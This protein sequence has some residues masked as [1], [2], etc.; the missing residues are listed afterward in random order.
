MLDR[1]FE[2][3]ELTR[4]MF[5]DLV[6]AD[7]ETKGLFHSALKTAEAK[8]R[9]R[10]LALFQGNYLEKLTRW[11]EEAPAL[12]EDR[13][14]AAMDKL[15]VLFSRT[16]LRKEACEE[17][18]IGSKRRALEYRELMKSGFPELDDCITDQMRGLPYPP[19]EKPVEAG[20]SVLRLPPPDRSV[21]KSDSLFDC[22][23]GRKSVR[24]YGSDPLSLEELSF[25]LWATQGLRQKAEH[26]R[27]S[28][29]TVPSGGARQPLESYIA[30]FKVEALAPGLYRYLPFPHSL[31]FER[32]IPA[33]GDRLREA[34]RGQVF[35]SDCA[36]LFIWSAI[37]Y[38]TE[39]RYL[40]EAKKIILQDSG[41]ACQNL[42]LAAE[43]IG[44]GVCA[45]G[46]YDQGK[47]DGLVG[48]D[49][50]DE[51]VIYLASVGKR[52]IL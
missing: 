15:Q 47:I 52:I 36:A 25:L 7:E 31:C 46:A 24:K 38:R 51:F 45:I 6:Y 35:A 12:P 4:T 17:R 19:L 48:L 34:C 33:M 26:R 18:T 20:A 39:Y 21:L 23:A 42:Y 29:R 32:D 22:V 44:C 13:Y 28:L 9:D 3:D 16:E 50:R 41:H 11:I 1:L 5:L 40:T 43:A 49:G 8:D 14:R 37:P 30:L 2:L 10:V 27:F